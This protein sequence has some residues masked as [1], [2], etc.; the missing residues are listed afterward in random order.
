MHSSS[1]DCHASRRP[2]DA[3]YSHY[4]S[5]DR[6]PALLLGH[7]DVGHRP[8]SILRRDARMF[9][10]FRLVLLLVESLLDLRH[11]AALL[12]LSRVGRSAGV[13]G[14]VVGGLGCKSNVSQHKLKYVQ[15][16]PKQ[17]ICCY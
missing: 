7:Q 16:P 2:S 15:K 12:L 10:R 4:A 9:N 3:L 11:E 8:R 6:S 5:L 1:R 13:L 14:G 17:C